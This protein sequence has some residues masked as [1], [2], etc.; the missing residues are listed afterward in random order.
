V[1]KRQHT[2]TADSQRYER[3]INERGVLLQRK[4][5]YMRKVAARRRLG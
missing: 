2:L 5:D 4:E 3:L 1:A